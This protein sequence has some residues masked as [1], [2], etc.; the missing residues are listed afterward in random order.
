MRIRWSEEELETLEEMVEMFTVKQKS[1]QRQPALQSISS[2]SSTTNF[3]ISWRGYN[4]LQQI[5]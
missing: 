4:Q 3:E 2:T 1:S 5:S